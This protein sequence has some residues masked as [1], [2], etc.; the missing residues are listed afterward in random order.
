MTLVWASVIVG[1]HFWSVATVYSLLKS[2]Q[3][4]E[5]LMN[6]CEHSIWMDV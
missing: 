6:N 4:Y 3:M 5:T 1:E 2:T